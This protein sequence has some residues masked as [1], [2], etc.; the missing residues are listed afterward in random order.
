MTIAIGNDHAGPDY[1]AAIVEL[2]ESKGITVT[3]YGT[4]SF[5]SVDYPDFAH[6]VAEAVDTKKVEEKAPLSQIKVLPFKEKNEW[7]LTAKYNI[8]KKIEGTDGG[9]VSTKV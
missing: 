8:G 2:L 4:D 6:K 1:K 3:N 9:N 5:D 7:S